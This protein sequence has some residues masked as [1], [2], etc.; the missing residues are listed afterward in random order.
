MKET[1]LFAAIASIITMAFP[2]S[3][4][5][6]KGFYVSAHGT[7]L[8]SVRFNG[9]DVDNQD[10]DYKTKSSITFGVGAGYNFT[11]HFGVATEAMYSKEKQQY[12]DHSVKYDEQ[13]NFVKVP[14]LLTYNTNPSAR[15]ILTA[16]AGP[17]LGIL[18]SAKI[19]KSSIAALNGNS[20]DRYKDINFGAD[21]NRCKN[22]THK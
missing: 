18:R 21:R 15:V 20:K 14:L 1:I 19:S 22:K 17:Q 12:K 10:M 8:L 4:T 5:A 16:K 11:D 6:Q 7:P 3:S 13:L 2:N 9:S